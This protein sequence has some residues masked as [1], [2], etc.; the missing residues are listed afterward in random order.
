MQF[1]KDK[2]ERIFL[3]PHLDP[4]LGDAICSVRAANAIDGVGDKG[5]SSKG[6]NRRRPAR[7]L[8]I[9]T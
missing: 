2:L 4:S 1:S 6:I 5:R 3:I 8:L 7:I 9:P